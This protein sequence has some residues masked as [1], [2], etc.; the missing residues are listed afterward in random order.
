MS[1]WMKEW[2]QF[3]TLLLALAGF[4]GFITVRLDRMEDRLTA[5][6]EANREAIG[7]VR[8]ELSHE[9]ATLGREVSELRGELKGRDLIAGMEANR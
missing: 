8:T 5:R 3:V 4:Y 9:I 7:A 1:E 2:G 6:I